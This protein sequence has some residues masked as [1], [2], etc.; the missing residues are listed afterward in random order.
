M[1]QRRISVIAVIVPTPLTYMPEC[2]R[3]LARMSAFDLPA[4][5]PLGNK[6]GTYESLA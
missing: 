3:S 2:F 4:N 5:S 6:V 1:L